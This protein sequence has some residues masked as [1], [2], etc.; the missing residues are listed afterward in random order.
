MNVFF[1]GTLNQHVL[2]P[3]WHHHRY[4]T[5]QFLAV[6]FVTFEARSRLGESIDSSTILVNSRHHQAID[7]VGEG[8][9]VVAR[10]D[11]GII[12]A[13][14]HRVHPYMM[15][16]QWHPEGRIRTSKADRRILQS[17]AAAAL[18]E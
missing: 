7:D 4:G 18:R 10:S 12:E 11:D 16:V 3:E 9:L 13:V 15:G 2:N 6:H 17:F 1:G 8:L 14:E 5:A